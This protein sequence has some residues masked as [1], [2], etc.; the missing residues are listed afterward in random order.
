MIDCLYPA[1]ATGLA[2]ADVLLG[3]A[4]PAGRLPFSWPT[5]AN[6]V[7]PEANY[8][9]AGRTYRYAQ[10]NV[11]WSFGHGLSYSSFSYGKASLSTTSVDAA[12]C[13]SVNITVAVRN[14]GGVAGETNGRLFG[15]RFRLKT[16]HLPRQARDKHRENPL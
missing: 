8:T 2:I 7:P 3:L 9:M 16:E 15:S 6:D 11:K 1:E 12:E 4:S 13:S 10:K 14:T 5:K